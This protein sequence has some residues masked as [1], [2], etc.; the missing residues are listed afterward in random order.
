MRCVRSASAPAR[1][2]RLKVYPD[3]TEEKALVRLLRDHHLI[4]AVASA[5]L[6]SSWPVAPHLANDA[7][8]PK[9]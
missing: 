7:G 1:Y 6:A 3:A 8:G 2:R 4:D 9:Q 5:L